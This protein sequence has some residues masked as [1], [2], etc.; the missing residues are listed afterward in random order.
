MR[1]NFDSKMS[2]EM[3][4][5]ETK[6]PSQAAAGTFLIQSHGHEFV[7]S[8]CPIPQPMM[9]KGDTALIHAHWHTYT[10]DLKYIGI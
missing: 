6:H 1:S 2:E 10:L 3:A 5:T 7:P 4:D 8:N 9:C